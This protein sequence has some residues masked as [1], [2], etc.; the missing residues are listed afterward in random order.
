[1]LGLYTGIRRKPCTRLPCR[2][3][4]CVLE[5]KGLLIMYEERDE[6]T[7]EK[8]MAA[9]EEVEETAAEPKEDDYE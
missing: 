7:D 3:D 4:S 1:M 5:D 9:D 8:L 6:D 2:Y